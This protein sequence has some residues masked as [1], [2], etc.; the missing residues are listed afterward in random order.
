MFAPALESV[1]LTPGETQTFISSTLVRE[2]AK[3]GGE[4]NEFVSP[5]VEKALIEKF[6][7]S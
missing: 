1:F 5:C 4:I 3:L 6:S 2:V 7:K